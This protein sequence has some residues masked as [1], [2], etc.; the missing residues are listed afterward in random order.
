[1]RGAK[2]CG[3]SVNTLAT[4]CSAHL[5]QEAGLGSS[6]SSG[7]GP[8]LTPLA[9]PKCITL[10]FKLGGLS[11]DLAGGTGC[12]HDLDRS[13]AVQ[14]LDRMGPFAPLIFSFKT[15]TSTSSSFFF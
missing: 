2:A 12:P 4:G 6:A 15:Y 8:Q 5:A 1:M 11:A 7:S 14:F 3:F 13:W 9:E 10:L